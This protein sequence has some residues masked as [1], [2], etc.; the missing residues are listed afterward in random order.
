MTFADPRLAR[1]DGFRVEIDRQHERAEV[2]LDRPPFNITEM[3]QRD[4][5]RRRDGRC[6]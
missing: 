1:P 6:D 4:Q 2:I 3:W 5:L